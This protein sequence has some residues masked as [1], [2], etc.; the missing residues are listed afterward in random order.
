MTSLLDMFITNTFSYFLKGKKITMKLGVTRNLGT[1]SGATVVLRI[2][3][4]LVRT[5][6]LLMSCPRQVSV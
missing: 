2:E 6:P 3:N 4:G 1:I 5:S